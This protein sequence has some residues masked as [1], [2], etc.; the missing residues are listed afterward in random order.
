MDKRI[1]E[2]IAALRASGV[3]VSLA[4]SKDAFEAID[5]LG[6]MERDQFKTGLR[7]TLIKDSKDIPQFEELFPMFFQADQPSMNNP[8]KNL[9][10]EEAEML[11]QALR[12]FTEHMRKMMEKLLE[13]HPLSPQEMEQL[14]RFVNMDEV[15]DLRYQNWKVRQMEQALQF[16]RSSESPGRVDAAP[17]GNGDE[18]RKA[19]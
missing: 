7:T 9:S 16:K 4:E 5:E 6:V 19:G 18:P 13:G 2:F 10:S 1:V 8:S 17:S 14:D 12:Q 15:D 3:R 11:A